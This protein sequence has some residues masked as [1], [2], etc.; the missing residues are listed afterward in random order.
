VGFGAV[1][2]YLAKAILQHPDCQDKLELAFVG[3]ALDP[4]AP[5]SDPDIPKEA[6]LANL[7][8][9]AAT[10]PDLIVEVAHQSISR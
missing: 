2:R 4:A 9:F 5:L 1:G 8:D 7:D 10:K 6:V 3:C